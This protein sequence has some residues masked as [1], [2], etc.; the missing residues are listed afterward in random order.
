MEAAESGGGRRE[1]V[2]SLQ[3]FDLGG[4]FHSS[5]VNLP[6]SQH[7]PARLSLA[8]ERNTVFPLAWMFRYSL[9]PFNTNRG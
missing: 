7:C 4:R 2:K 6:P 9:V 8:A 1:R 5:S 3:S